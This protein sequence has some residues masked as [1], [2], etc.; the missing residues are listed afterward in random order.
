MTIPIEASSDQ[1]SEAEAELSRL[2]QRLNNHNNDLQTLD[3]ADEF[4]DEDLSTRP[5]VQAHER[6]EMQLQVTLEQ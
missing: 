3:E 5:M 2:N 1:I 6:S 4:E